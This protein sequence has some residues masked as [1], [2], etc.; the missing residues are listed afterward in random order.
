MPPLP[1]RRGQDLCGCGSEW[2]LGIFVPAQSRAMLPLACPQKGK[3]R[4]THAHKYTEIYTCTK[5]TTHPS[6]STFIHI[7]THTWSHI[8]R[9]SAGHPGVASMDETRLVARAA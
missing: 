2:G 7:I 9:A 4:H 6:Q 1:M 5:T 3:Y 8:L